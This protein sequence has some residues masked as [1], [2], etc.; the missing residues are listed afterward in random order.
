MVAYVTV[1][2]RGP[3]TDCLQITTVV[4]QLECVNHSEITPNTYNF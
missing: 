4:I 2:S 1:L 3:S